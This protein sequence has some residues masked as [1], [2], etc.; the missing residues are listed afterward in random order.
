VPAV[1]VGARSS[2]AKPLFHGIKAE[3][4]PLTGDQPVPLGVND[5]P[6]TL[7]GEGPNPCPVPVQ[8][9]ALL[10]GDTTYSLLVPLVLLSVHFPCPPQIQV[11]DYVTL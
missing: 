4:E 1:L 10:P 9:V 2:S 11:A 5:L 7:V 3:V 8:L 6:T